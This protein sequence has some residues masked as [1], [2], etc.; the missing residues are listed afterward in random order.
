MSKKKNRIFKKI[1]LS[2]KQNNVKKCNK[3]MAKFYINQPSLSVL[4]LLYITLFICTFNHHHNYVHS[5]NITVE[6]AKVKMMKSKNINM[7]D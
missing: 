1:D 2:R 7:T 4:F 6:E 5:A 3:I